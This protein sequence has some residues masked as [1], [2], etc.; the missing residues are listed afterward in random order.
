MDDLVFA[1]FSSRD[2]DGAREL[3]GIVTRLSRALPCPPRRIELM[4]SGPL[5]VRPSSRVFALLIQEGESYRWLKETGCV[6]SRPL[7]GSRKDALETAECLNSALPRQDGT[8]YLL[9]AHGSHNHSVRYHDVLSEGLRDDIILTDLD[10]CRSSIPDC[11]HPVLVPFLLSYGHH[12]KAAASQLE[13][14]NSALTVVRQ[15]ILS[16]C[17]ALEAVFRR[18]LQEIM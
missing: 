15:G 14:M 2:E 7:L 1:L 4:H 17:P 3:D 12:A 16:T 10:S 18:R 11:P 8:A 6:L 5:D 13:R 9:L